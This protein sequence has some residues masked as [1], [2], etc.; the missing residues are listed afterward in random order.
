MVSEQLSR[1][2]SIRD[3]IQGEV[4]RLVH[5]PAPDAGGRVDVAVTRDGIEG[6]VTATVGRGWSIG[7]WAAWM[8]ATGWAVAGK[9]SGSWGG[10]KEG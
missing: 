6:E 9:I 5:A 4:D 8:K 7:A 2:A 10:K 3:G 1:H